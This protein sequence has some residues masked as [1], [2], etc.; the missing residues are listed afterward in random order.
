MKERLIFVHGWGCSPSIWDQ[1]IENLPEFDCQTINLGFIGKNTSRTSANIADTNLEPSIYITHSLGTMWALKFKKL[2]MKA[3]IAI[4]GFS[5]FKSFT[6]P[7]TL[8]RMQLKL[9]RAPQI[10]MQEFYDTTK[11][12]VSEDLNIEDLNTGLEW[13]MNWDLTEELKDLTCSVKSIY[14]DIDPILDLAQMQSHWSDYNS[15]IV[16]K[17]GH[18]LPLTNAQDCA[19][20]IKSIAHD[21]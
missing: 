3:F 9:K 13:L 8:K 11:L 10:Q 16:E 2:S 7:K 18:N 21:L 17:G 12:P 4:N 14:G 19:T 20:I 1:T 6:T 15:H 5:C